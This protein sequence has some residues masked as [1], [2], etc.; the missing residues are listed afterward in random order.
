MS[1]P[2]QQC[3]LFSDVFFRPVSRAAL[4]QVEKEVSETTDITKL[5][6]GVLVKG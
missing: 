4:H 5:L 3:E 2:E 1:S 6:D